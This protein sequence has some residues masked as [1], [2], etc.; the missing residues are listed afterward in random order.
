MT[1]RTMKLADLELALDWAAQEGWN[2][3]LDDA[4]A[5]L[6]ADPD[7]FLISEV[8]GKPAA[9]ISVV[10][11]DPTFA[12]LGLYICAPEFRGQGHGLALWKAG[13][14]HAGGR[15]IGLDGVPDQQ[16][17]YARSGFDPAGKTVRYTGSLPTDAPLHTEVPQEIAAISA[18]DAEFSGFTRP[19]FAQAWF[20][21]TQTRRTFTLGKGCFA[22][23]R[24]CRDGVKI[25]PLY[26]NSVSELDTLFALIS[27]QFGRQPVTL[28][29][30]LQSKALSDYVSDMGFTPS[31]ETARM[32]KGKAPLLKLP[33]FSATATLE[34]G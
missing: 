33:V 7:G 5:F 13:I 11:H 16:A 22:T 14:L 31:F 15:C 2:P 25:G 1:I 23:A 20:A 21:D 28:D 27:R 6:A 34:L 24:Q 32:Y 4:A 17:N 30:P 8:N 18:A 19:N 10:N 29:I 3:G 12:F 26:A 9:V